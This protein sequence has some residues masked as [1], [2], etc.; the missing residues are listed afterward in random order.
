MTGFQLLGQ[1]VGGSLGDRFNKRLLCVGCMIA[2][3]VGLYLLTYADSL[4][5]VGGFAMLHG[6]AWGIR[7][8]QMV[9]IRADYFG[10][11]SFGRIMGI[12]SLVVMLG[13]IG[14]PMIC[15]L[16]V[17]HYGIYRNAFISIG[18]SSLMGAFL[19]YMARKPDFKSLK[20]RN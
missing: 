2:H 5:M 13:M 12:S 14:G 3:G 7:G 9:A 8:P 1:F 10:A 15:G 11:K 6:I 20:A 19:F 4:L 16:I 18:F 17:D